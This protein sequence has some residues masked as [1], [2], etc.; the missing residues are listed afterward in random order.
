[1]SLNEK[2]G[3]ESE[4]ANLYIK[5]WLETQKYNAEIRK[6]VDDN[7]DKYFK[8]S[9]NARDYKSKT[10]D[11]NNIRQYNLARDK[12]ISGFTALYD[13]ISEILKID[14]NITIDPDFMNLCSIKGFC[15]SHAIDNIGHWANAEREYQLSKN[16]DLPG[17]ISRKSKSEKI[18]RSEEGDQ[19]WYSLQF[20]YRQLE[21]AKF[22]PNYDIVAGMWN[23]I[24]VQDRN[25]VQ[26]IDHWYYI[27]NT[28]ISKKI[29]MNELY[30]GYFWRYN[31]KM[32]S[33]SQAETL[34]ILNNLYRHNGSKP[35]GTL[36]CCPWY[37]DS[38]INPNGD[39][40]I[41]TNIIPHNVDNKKIHQ[42]E[43]SPIVGKSIDGIK[44]IPI[45][46]E[47]HKEFVDKKIQNVVISPKSRKDLIKKV[48]FNEKSRDGKKGYFKGKDGTHDQHWDQDTSVSY[49]DG[50][51]SEECEE[52]TC[53]YGTIFVKDG[54][55]TKLINTDNDKCQKLVTKKGKVYKIGDKY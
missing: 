32:T 14:T 38:T 21:F 43:N 17:S 42:L 37:P 47:N 44:T 25:V 45:E 8:N 54:I 19:A 23:L 9:Q 34:Y 15:K 5:K 39:D 50:I 2:H 27:H 40:S 18:V 31:A 49:D 6:M 20:L 7:S 46:S 33:E 55:I 11:P 10:V 48:K 52:Y 41:T 13:G 12:I 4:I 1:M 35:L 29:N 36:E 53:S 30:R 28:Q 51:E 3:Y 22:V 16:I 26:V 24:A